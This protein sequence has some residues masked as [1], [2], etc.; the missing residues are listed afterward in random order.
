MPPEQSQAP[1][2][3]GDGMDM[4]SATEQDH[5]ISSDDQGK[6]AYNNIDGPMAKFNSVITAYDTT[7]AIVSGAQAFA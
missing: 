1:V 5:L 4:D 7:L 3:P 6:T 2:H